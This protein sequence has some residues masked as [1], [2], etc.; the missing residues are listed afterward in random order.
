MQAYARIGGAQ[1]VPFLRA[2]LTDEHPAIRK[3]A[4]AA[5]QRFGAKA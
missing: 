2:A 5:L 4:R 3:A 1:V